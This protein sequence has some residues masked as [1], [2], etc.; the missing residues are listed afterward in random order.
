MQ[1]ILTAVEDSLAEAWRR[2]CGDLE[3][4]RIH[5]GS[6][7]DI[8]CD[9]IVSPANSFGFMD[10]GI[11]AVYMRHFGHGIQERVQSM[12]RERH[13][14]EL[15]VGSADVVDT[16][17][18]SVPYLIVAPT[19]RVPMTLAD[20]VNPYLA[21]RAVFRLVRHGRFPFAT[22]HAEPIRDRIRTIALP[23]LG[24]GVGHVGP[25]ICA[26][27]VRQ[28]IDDIILDRFVSPQSWVEASV[29]HQ[30]LYRDR[31]ARLP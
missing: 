26:R 20:S 2:F 28:A 21:A 14:G 6:I 22:S 23:G 1:I 25:N 29:R 10:G 16:E 11:D 3:F 5:R 18:P 30:L 27:Q 4:V 19:M 7:L 12:I 31:P 13:H 8:P 24:T 9:A 17:H 15:L